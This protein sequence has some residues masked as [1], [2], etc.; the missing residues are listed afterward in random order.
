M[1]VLT[2]RVGQQIRIADEVEIKVLE[3]VG[4]KVRLGI[5]APCD[6]PV[7]REEIY[8]RLEQNAGMKPAFADLPDTVCEM[9][10]LV[11][12]Q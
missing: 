12:V 2:R 6:M 8:R 4:N 7:H 5:T 3:V 11:A 10:L 9:E 1:L